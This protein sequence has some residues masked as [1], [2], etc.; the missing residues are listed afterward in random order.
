MFS[1]IYLESDNYGVI[2]NKT[3]HFH[4]LSKESFDLMADSAKEEG[5]EIRGVT[6][7]KDGYEC[8]PVAFEEKP[9][10][11]N[12]L[13]YVEKYY[14]ASRGSRPETIYTSC[15]SVLV[16]IGFGGARV[17]K[18]ELCVKLAVFAYYH[19]KVSPLVRMNHNVVI[20]LLD[21]IC[22]NYR[23]IGDILMKEPYPED[24]MKKFRCK[25]I[26]VEV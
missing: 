15:F 14:E 26:N 12:V 23:G 8:T 3:M 25:P 2:D 16:S 9:N 20:E 19:L 24:V 13:P 1:L 18:E 6:I 22:K 7:T 4:M 11:F 10:M 21:G 17:T 5:V